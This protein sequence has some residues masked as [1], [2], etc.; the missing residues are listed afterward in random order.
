MSIRP[1]DP[2][3]YKQVKRAADKNFASKTGI[4][5]S[6]WIVME[7]KRRGGKYIGAKPKSTG[8]KRWY[9]EDWIDLNRPIRK[10]KKIVGYQPCGRSSPKRG[11]T[12]PLCRPSRRVS[13]STPKTYKELSKGSIR[14]AKREKSKV[15]SKGNIRFSGGG[16]SDRSQYYGRRS[17]VMVPVP[18]NVKK[19]AEQAFVLRKIGFKGATETGWRRAK[20]LATKEAIP[21]EDLRYMRNWYARHIITSYPTF[22]AWKREGKPESPTWFNKHGIISWMTWGGNA[23]FRWVNSQRV[24]DLLNRHYDKDYRKIRV[25]V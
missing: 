18:K 3:L 12:Y 6:S 10:G 5:K 23:G 21:I 1:A 17:S 24:L 8:L 22:K 11:D 16:A 14:K 9:R 20:Q 15:R 13:K 4:Y 19:W 25:K 2:T 7:Y